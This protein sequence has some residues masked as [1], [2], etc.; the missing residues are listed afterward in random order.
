MK[1]STTIV[2]TL[3]TLTSGANGLRNLCCFRQNS[4]GRRDLGAEVL[5]QHRN[6]DECNDACNDEC[7][8]CLSQSRYCHE[9]GR[10]SSDDNNWGSCDDDSDACCDETGAVV[11]Q[12]DDDC[13]GVGPPGATGTYCPDQPDRSRDLERCCFEPDAVEFL[14]NQQPGPGEGRLL[15]DLS[16]PRF[17]WSRNLQE[18]CDVCGDASCSAAICYD[19]EDWCANN[20]DDF[21]YLCGN[22]CCDGEGNVVQTNQ[23][24]A[25]QTMCNSFPAEIEESVHF[26]PAETKT[27]ESS[28]DPHIKTFAGIWYD[29][30]GKFFNYFFCGIISGHPQT[31]SKRYHLCNRRM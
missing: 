15:R 20:F 23:D 26:C 4:G 18:N 16:I 8:F 14:E 27:G 21:L 13:S 22:D 2:L 30:F 29:F 17:P 9:V 24:E 1:F 12:V 11:L 5:F 31:N 7:N 10:L 28:G 25:F 19:L 3:T 6:L